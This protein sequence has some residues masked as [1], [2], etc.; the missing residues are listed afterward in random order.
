MIEIGRP[1]ND[2]FEK[3][4]KILLP[5]VID[6]LKV[7][8]GLFKDIWDVLSPILEALGNVVG[9]IHSII[10]GVGEWL[11]KMDLLKPVIAGIIFAINPLLGTINAIILGMQWIQRN[12]PEF[13]KSKEQKQ[14]EYKENAD[15][16]FKK[17]QDRSNY[18]PEQLDA[19]HK[20]WGWK[21]D[22]SGNYVAPSA[23]PDAL[24]PGGGTG[25]GKFND[26]PTKAPGETSVSGKAVA[27]RNI[28]INIDNLSNVEKMNVAGDG[29]KQMSK[30]DFEA[31]MK[32]MLVRLLR[33]VE[34]SYE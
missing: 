17:M 26:K 28:T 6:L 18:T 9:L 20:S 33:G 24:L 25:D 15:K 12:K 4:G 1:I 7:F 21:Q 8:K 16:A 13:M 30:N 29:G 14:V 22:A 32:E 31:Y 34:T 23:T 5:V 2:T 27:V 10:T 19:L 3:L 11:D